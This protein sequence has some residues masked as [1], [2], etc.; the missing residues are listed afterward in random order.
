M[1]RRHPARSPMPYVMR[2]RFSRTPLRTLARKLRAVL[3]M[4]GAAAALYATLLPLGPSAHA[5]ELDYTFSTG[6]NEH[7][8]PTTTGKYSIMDMQPA[9]SGPGVHSVELEIRATGY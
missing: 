1:E 9:I 2:T 5:D 7:Y 6:S 8:F 4:L 3:L